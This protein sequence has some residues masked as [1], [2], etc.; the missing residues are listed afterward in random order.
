MLVQ[1]GTARNDRTDL[2]LAC[3]L[4]GI[5]GSLNASAFYSVGFFA[6][7][8][9]GNVSVLSDHIAIAQWPSALFYLTIVITFILGAGASTLMIN[10]GRRRNIHG[11]YAY[12]ILTEAILLTVLG[13]ADLWL[14]GTWRVPVLVLGLAFL[15]GLQNAVVTRISDARVRTT[16][17]SGMATDIGIELGIAFDILRGRDQESDAAHNRSKLRLHLLT[18]F[19]FMLGGVVGVIFYR[20]GG[21]WLLILAAMMLFIIALLGIFHARR[22]AGLAGASVTQKNPTDLGSIEL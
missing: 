21:G 3:A 10:G 12:S 6:A 16:H 4:A 7:N 14:L 20:T 8:M 19:A 13:F 9:T 17:V 15:M 1:Q 2:K 11:I 5:A 22:T 18:I